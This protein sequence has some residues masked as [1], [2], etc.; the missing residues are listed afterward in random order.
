MGDRF[1]VIVSVGGDGTINEIINGMPELDMPLGIIP[2]GSGNDFARSCCIPHDSV[3]EAIRILIQGDARRLDVGSVNGRFFINAMGLGFEGQVNA[4]CQRLTKVRGALKY[5]AGI[6]IVF[7]TY[8]RVSINLTSTE[9][10][11][12]GP[13]FLVSIGNGWN[14]GGGLQ[15][16]PHAQ[17]DDGLLDICFIKAIS[18]WRIISNFSRLTDGTIRDLPEIQYFRTNSL[19][20][21][22][23]KPVPVHA[24]GEQLSH[25]ANKIEICLHPGA[26]SIIGNWIV[27][28]R[29]SSYK[30][31]ARKIAD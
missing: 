1:D 13:V 4:V 2:I 15:L 11:S 9:F 30:N 24:D 28:S 17:L 6:G 19:T 7:L 26:Q 10:S 31:K 12:D 18:R 16:T 25:L 3:S 29:T 20:I 5:L 27:D 22:C 21:E 23:S 8:R 14:V